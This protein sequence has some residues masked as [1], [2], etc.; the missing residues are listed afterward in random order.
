MGKKRTDKFIENKASSAGQR[1]FFRES[2]L[3][4]VET[5]SSLFRQRLCGH[6]TWPCKGTRIKFYPVKDTSVSLCEY[7]LYTY[8]QGDIKDLLYFIFQL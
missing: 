7:F 4:L 3:L 1:E 2:R 8:P 6:K 5:Q